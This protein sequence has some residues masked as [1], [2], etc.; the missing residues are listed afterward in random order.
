MEADGGGGR[1]REVKRAKRG[2]E[3]GRRRRRRVE[4]VQKTD[5]LRVWLI[6]R[7]DFEDYALRPL[8]EIL[9]TIEKVMN[10]L[11]IHGHAALALK[12][13]SDKK[14]FR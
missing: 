14:G 2:G 7:D 5:L 13:T 12:Q 10:D 8:V 1:G 9:D 6:L 3:E 4:R 11:L